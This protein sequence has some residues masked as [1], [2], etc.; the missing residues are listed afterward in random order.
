MK[1]LLLTLKS[2]LTGCL[3]T[4]LLLIIVLVLLAILITFVAGNSTRIPMEFQLARD[5]CFA[6]G[7]CW[8]IATNMCEKEGTYE[9]KRNI[10][11]S[12]YCIED[13]DCKEGREINT[14]HGKVI[15]N[16]ENCLKYNWDW[17]EKR[18]KCKIK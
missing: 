6:K 4:S 8:N 9:C 1:K 13:G 3:I 5:N 2:I 10:L 18:R 17:D 11:D 12:D 14:E 15:V 7:G 16:K